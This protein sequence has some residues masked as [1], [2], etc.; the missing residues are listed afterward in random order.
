LSEKRLVGS[1]DIRNLVTADFVFESD[2][3]RSAVHAQASF[4]LWFPVHSG[5]YN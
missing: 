3:K 4:R 5:T 1:D 2:R